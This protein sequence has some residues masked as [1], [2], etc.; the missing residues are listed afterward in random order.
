MTKYF[1]EKRN[2]EILDRLRKHYPDAK[3]KLKF[4][5]PF[6]L[7][8]ATILSAQCTDDRVNIVTETLF[9]KYR[10][11]EDYLKVSNEELEKD[12]FSTGFYKQKAKAIKACC[13]ALVEKYNGKI[14]ANIDEM[15][16]IPGIGRKTASV[17][18]GNAF[19]IPAIAVD[20]HVKRLSNIFHF[21]KEENPDKIEE[22]LK[23]IIPEDEWV[24]TSHRIA[25]HGRLI[26]QA[27]KPKCEICF[28]ND[29]CPSAFKTNKRK[30][31]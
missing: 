29:I 21:V 3:I 10:K 23:K 5:N 24:I 31:K 4:K 28:L 19:G 2:Q 11:P 13:Q 22:Q 26:C 7:L 9:K 12:I 14:P 16:K 20:T 15:T 25:T 30:S 8:I 17:V 18:L 27:K 1:D 6:E